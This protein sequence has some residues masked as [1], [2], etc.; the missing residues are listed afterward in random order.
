MKKLKF[1]T[2]IVMMMALL[3][4]AAN[5]E[6]A[7]KT[8]KRVAPKK[9]VTAY[10]TLPAFVKACQYKEV[11]GMWGDDSFTGCFD[12]KKSY[13]PS[14]FDGKICGVITFNDNTLQPA[15]LIEDVG[16]DGTWKFNLVDPSTLE[17]VYVVNGGF[18]HTGQ[19]YGEPCDHQYNEGTVKKLQNNAPKGNGEEFQ[20]TVYY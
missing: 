16:K 5:T 17:R 13:K 19:M 3:C 2:A 11:D 4:G 12:F 10:T 7:V 6:A 18:E 1:L 15:Y 8:K 20:L 14:G 9:A